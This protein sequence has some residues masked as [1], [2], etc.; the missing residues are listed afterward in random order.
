[1]PQ[2]QVNPQYQTFNPNMMNNANYINP[3]MYYNPSKSQST[4]IC[5]RDKII[6]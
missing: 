5:N 6:C 3:Q 4:Q 2:Q 1:M